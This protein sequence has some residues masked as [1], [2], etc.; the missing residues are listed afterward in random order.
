LFTFQGSVAVLKR[1]DHSNIIIFPCQA[2]KIKNLLS[3]HILFSVPFSILLKRA[4]V[5]AGALLSINSLYYFYF[6]N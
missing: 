4:P 3:F 1:L 5:N 2:Q 6:S